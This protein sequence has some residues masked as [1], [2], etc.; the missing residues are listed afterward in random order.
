MLM[1]SSGYIAKVTL[2]KLNWFELVNQIE[3]VYWERLDLGF[4][5]VLQEIKEG[6]KNDFSLN[7][8]DCWKF[9]GEP[10]F[11]QSA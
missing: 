6:R 10:Q 9:W 1:P 4:C 8:S 3:L 5:N 11:F 2:D 7:D